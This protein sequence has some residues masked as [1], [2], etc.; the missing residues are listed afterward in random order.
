MTDFG[1]TQYKIRSTDPKDIMFECNRV[2]ELLS[3]RLDRIEGLRGYPVLYGRQT[4]AHDVV[5]TSANRGVVLKDDAD[6]PNYWRVTIDSSG[7]LQQTNLG[8][9]YEVD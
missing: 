9:N 8:R 4:T 7:V 1:D 2:F 6:P 3:N 5:H